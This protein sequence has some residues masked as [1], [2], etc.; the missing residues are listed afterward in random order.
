MNKKQSVHA[1]EARSTDA[2]AEQQVQEQESERSDPDGILRGRHR[3]RRN[4]GGGE[5]RGEA[6]GVYAAHPP[7]RLRHPGL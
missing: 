1:C 7:D 5:E 2:G 3:C 4:A 6:G